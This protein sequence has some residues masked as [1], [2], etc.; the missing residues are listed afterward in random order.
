M[1]GSNAEENTNELAVGSR[2]RDRYRIC[3]RLGAGGFGRTYGAIDLGTTPPRPC[4]VKQCFV[5]GATGEQR[6]FA[7]ALFGREARR[8]AELGAHPQIPELYDTFAWGEHQYLVQ[9]WIEG[10]DLATW[11]TGIPRAS[12]G[13]VLDLLAQVLPVV[14]YVHERGTIHR[15]IKPANLLRDRAG[16]V[17]II[18]FGAAK[19]ATEAA[20][21]QTGTTIGS[22]EYVA[23]EQLHGRATF[24][25]DV[26]SLGVT[27]IHLL[28]GVSPFDLYDH[29]R[30]VWVWQSFLP[31]PV[32][33][34][35]EFILDR[36]VAP[37][38]SKRYADARAVLADLQ[39][40]YPDRVPP[41]PPP[42]AP[43]GA[44]A[45][46]PETGDAEDEVIRQ[47]CAGD[48]EFEFAL[49][50]DFD[51]TAAPPAVAIDCADLDRALRAG[52]WRAANEET[53]RLL[54]AAAGATRRTWLE[55]DEIEQFPCAELQAIDALW[56]EQSAGRFGFSVQLAIWRA[57]AEPSYRDLGDRLGWFE[58]GRW[59]PHAQ[60]DYRATAAEGHLPAVRWWYGSAVWLRGLFRRLQVCARSYQ[61]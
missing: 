54:L 59:R 53:H 38:T 35:L 10:E 15:D 56:V 4:V 9:A 1:F 32:E 27:C 47:F 11:L 18:D 29:G 57:L 26:Y 42:R 45:P 3:Q 33:R 55:G 25:S 21:L 48:R 31:D 30:A 16:R 46:A 60:L 8:L 7:T 61:G 22:A 34:R 50:L 36:M 41:A 51:P 49:D 2:L 20:R 52:E 19:V 5:R 43:V 44:A 17:A 28:T 23:P 37:A 58:D 14:V 13:E 24:A 39:R 40:L 12:A 6:E